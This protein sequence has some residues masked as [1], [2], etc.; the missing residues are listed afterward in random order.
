MVAPY[1][2]GYTAAPK[3]PK[4]LVCRRTNHVSEKCSFDISVTFALEK[5]IGQWVVNKK[6]TKDN[7]NKRFQGYLETSDDCQL[8]LQCKINLMDIFN[9]GQ[10]YRESN[11]NRGTFDED[12]VVFVR[13]YKDNVKSPSILKEL[14]MFQRGFQHSQNISHIPP[15][16][17]K[18]NT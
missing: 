3:Q 18:N 7:A 2:E 1:I 12:E 14:F 17:E 13:D 4:C 9:S 5:G 15:K 10:F 16:K 6:R 8:I 11:T